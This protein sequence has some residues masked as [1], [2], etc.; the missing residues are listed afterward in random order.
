MPVEL[1]CVLE[2]AS[3]LRTRFPCS[4]IPKIADGS[5]PLSALLEARSSLAMKTLRAGS[6]A[7]GS[8]LRRVLPRFI[9]RAV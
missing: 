3:S 1:A 9:T 6:F 8:L 5:G 7:T 2:E 4:A